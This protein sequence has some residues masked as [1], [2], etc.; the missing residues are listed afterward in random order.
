MSK[1]ICFMQ[2]SL[3]LINLMIESLPREIFPDINWRK[4]EDIIVH[5][6]FGLIMLI[7]ALSKAGCSSDTSDTASEAAT[8]AVTSAATEETLAQNEEGEF[9]PEQQALAKE[10][11]DMIDA[12]NQIVDRVNNTSEVLEDEE[13][14]AVMNELSEELTNL[15]QAFKSSETL[16]PEVMGKM[17]EA[18]DATNQFITEAETALNEIEN[19]RNE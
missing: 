12:Y 16:T 18:I 5:K 10:F 6:I 17:K 3:F 7:F 9:T 15:D 8:E 11:A 13:L 4:M 14:I 1:K 19:A 2:V